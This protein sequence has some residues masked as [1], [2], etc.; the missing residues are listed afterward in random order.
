MGKSTD[1]FLISRTTIRFGWN[2]VWDSV[3]EDKNKIY[4]GAEYWKERRGRETNE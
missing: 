4:K 3:W 1:N 2:S